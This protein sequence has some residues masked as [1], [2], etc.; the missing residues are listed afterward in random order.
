MKNIR[1]WEAISAA[2]PEILGEILKE[3]FT[4]C[5]LDGKGA[6]DSREF[7]QALNSMGVNECLLISYTSWFADAHRCFHFII[8]C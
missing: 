1:S 2:S 3:T 7:E 8:F 5:D 4:V 6:V